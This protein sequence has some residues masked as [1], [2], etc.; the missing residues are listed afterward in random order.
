MAA[1]III[2]II[3]GLRRARGVAME[4]RPTGQGR[5][6]GAGLGERS[7]PRMGFRRSGGKGWTWTGAAMKVDSEEGTAPEERERLRRRRGPGRGGAAW[8]PRLGRRCSG[9]EP[10]CGGRSCGLGSAL[11]PRLCRSRSHPHCSRQ[12]EP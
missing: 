6:G 11:A 7:V 1:L 3:W 2:V 10:L 9:E 5:K 4:L 8:A 12:P